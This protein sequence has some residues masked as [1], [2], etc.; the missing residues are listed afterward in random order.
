MWRGTG[1]GRSFKVEGKNGGLEAVL[2]VGSSGKGEHGGFVARSCDT[3]ENMLFCH[4]FNNDIV[5][6]AFIAY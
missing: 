2:P 3:C 6:F 1:G 4:G 5:V